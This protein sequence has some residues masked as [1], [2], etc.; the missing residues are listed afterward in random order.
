L[1]DKNFI[2]SGSIVRSVYLSFTT[3]SSSF[4]KQSV[5]NGNL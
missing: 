3:F 2:L 1:A 4:R 5:K